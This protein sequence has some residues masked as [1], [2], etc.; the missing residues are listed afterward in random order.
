[1]DCTTADQG[2]PEVER[3]HSKLVDLPVQP[4]IPQAA[5]LASG[6]EPGGCRVRLR[7]AGSCC[8]PDTSNLDKLE[9]F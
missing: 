2:Q 3:N 7:L 9:R 1:M 4:G 8:R 5:T 6:L